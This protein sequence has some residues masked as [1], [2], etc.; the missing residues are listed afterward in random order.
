MAL[1]GRARGKH[2]AVEVGAWFEKIENFARN[3]WLWNSS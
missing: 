1:E 3:A 2:V